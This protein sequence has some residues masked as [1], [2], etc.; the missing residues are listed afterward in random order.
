MKV[1]LPKN[2]SVLPSAVRHDDMDINV[3]YAFGSRVL[4]AVVDRNG[5]IIALDRSDNEIRAFSCSED[6]AEWLDCM[7]V[8]I[9]GTPS[10]ISFTLTLEVNN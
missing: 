3:V 9:C 2:L 5:G 1:I 6:L 10:G 7:D 4:V 8:P